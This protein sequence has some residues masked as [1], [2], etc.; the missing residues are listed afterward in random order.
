MLDNNNKGW[1]KKKTLK[2]SVSHTVIGD[3]IVVLPQPTDQHSS[4]QG[5]RRTISA[6]RPQTP[7]NG[8]P[9]TSTL[10]DVDDIAGETQDSTPRRDSKPKLARYTSLFSS[11]K[12]VNKGP[13]FAEPWSADAPPVF[14]PYPDPL[15]ALQSLRSFMFKAPSAAI[16]PSYSNALF[17]IF[18]SYGKLREQNQRLEELAQ[19]MIRDWT[20]MEEHFNMREADYK[21]EIRR[22]ELL[23]ARS[24]LGMTGYVHQVNVDFN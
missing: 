5:W 23:I 17:R 16:P 2:E 22:L 15:Y 3:D 18:D 6:S 11:L 1:R 13:E 21:G 9:A 24:A 12:D 10:R 8:A 19:E 4:H 20:R 14:E 7:V